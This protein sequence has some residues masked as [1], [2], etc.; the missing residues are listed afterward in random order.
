M[1]QAGLDSFVAEINAIFIKK[2]NLNFN[3]SN[4][5]DLEHL[6]AR[7]MPNLKKSESIIFH[8]MGITFPSTVCIYYSMFSYAG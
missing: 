8:C 3:I 1:G 6:S 7:K 2:I 5:D 4:S